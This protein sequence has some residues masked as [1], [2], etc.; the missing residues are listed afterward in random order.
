[1]C[2]LHGGRLHKDQRVRTMCLYVYTSRRSASQRP[3]CEKGYRL[4]AY[5]TALGFRKIRVPQQRPSRRPPAVGHRPPG[6]GPCLVATAGCLPLPCR[7]PNI[8][9]QT[10]IIVCLLCRTL[11]VNVCQC[12]IK[13]QILIPDEPFDLVYLRL[14]V[15]QNDGNDRKWTERDPRVGRG[16]LSI[17]LCPFKKSSGNIYSAGESYGRAPFDRSIAPM[18]VASLGAGDQCI[19]AAGALAGT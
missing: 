13:R 15:K 17:R 11:F 18:A 2:K 6:C 3:M 9:L 19:F 1:M 8:S 5:T 12:A 7:R 4:C 10:A 16:S 14:P